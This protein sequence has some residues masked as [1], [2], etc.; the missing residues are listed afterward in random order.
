MCLRTVFDIACIAPQKKPLLR[1]SCCMRFRSIPI[2]RA[3]TRSTRFARICPG[4]RAS[5]CA[6]GVLDELGEEGFTTAKVRKALDRLFAGQDPAF[7]RAVRK[8]LRDEKIAPAQIRAALA[9]IWQADGGT[10]AAAPSRSDR[11]MRAPRERAA[12]SSIDYGE[13]HHTERKPAETVEIY[14]ALD[15]M[16]QDFSPGNV[17]RRFLKH[18]VAWSLGMKT[19]CSAQLQQHE[20]RVWLELDPKVTASLAYARDVSKLGHQGIGDVELAIASVE[21]L[22]EAEP[23]IRQSFNVIA[24]ES[25]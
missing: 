20:L 10:T 13:K 1:T 7:L 18:T 15:R 25:K 2:I 3:G 16:C 17:S 24:A 23:F 6:H 4:C 14:R 11:P 8:E 22:R 9:R 21:R 19:F 12:R 5:R